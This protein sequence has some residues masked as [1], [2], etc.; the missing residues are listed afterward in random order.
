MCAAFMSHNEDDYR[1]YLGLDER[2]SVMPVDQADTYL[3]E[4][5]QKCAIVVMC[6]LRVGVLWLVMG[7]WMT[8][9]PLIVSLA[10]PRPPMSLFER[11]T[12]SNMVSY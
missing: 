7:L 8:A 6:V 9:G 3:S 4:R 11:H 12:Y 2:P 1:G 10:L 5:E